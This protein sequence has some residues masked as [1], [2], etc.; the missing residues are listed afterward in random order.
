MPLSRGS[1]SSSTRDRDSS[2]TGAPETSTNSSATASTGAS[3]TTTNSPATGDCTGSRTT[4]GAG[5]PQTSAA[6]TRASAS[7]WRVGATTPGNPAGASATAARHTTHSKARTA[8]TWSASAPA[9]ALRRKD[10]LQQLVG[11][12]EKILEFVTLRTEGLY[13]KLGG[14]FDASYG[15]IFRHIADLIDLDACFTGECSF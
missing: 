11:V 10:H 12:L 14:H 9:G 13:G 1:R 3:G 6:L 2:A 5:F 4:P 15:R 8:S 7:S